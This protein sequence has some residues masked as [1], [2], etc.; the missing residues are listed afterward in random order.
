[1]AD[2]AV[3]PA[4]PA[5]QRRCFAPYLAQFARYFSAPFVLRRMFGRAI[6]EDRSL[7]ALQLVW[8]QGLRRGSAA[9]EPCSAREDE[10]SAGEGGVAGEGSDRADAA[11][12][13]MQRVSAALRAATA[14]GDRGLIRRL[15]AERAAATTRLSLARQASGA[16]RTEATSDGLPKRHAGGGKTA[17]GDGAGD[18]RHWVWEEDRDG[19]PEFH[20]ARAA[21]LFAFVGVLKHPADDGQRL[22]A[23]SV[24]DG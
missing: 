22:F 3:D 23:R 1:M 6:A 17:R 2:T 8:R 13:D 9:A 20:A 21:E 14:A 15:M 18:V 4:T 5:A 16:D 19:T 12:A 10:A 11:A 24:S 7:A